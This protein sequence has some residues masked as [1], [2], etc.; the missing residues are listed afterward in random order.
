[1]PGENQHGDRIERDRH[2]PHRRPREREGIC[3]LRPE[4]RPHDVEP[5][6]CAGSRD[7]AI[8]QSTANGVEPVRDVHSSI[9]SDHVSWRYVES[10]TGHRRRRGGKMMTQRPRGGRGFRE[11]RYVSHAINRSR[12]EMMVVVVAM[13]TAGSQARRPCQL[14]CLCVEELTQRPLPLTRGAPA[15]GQSCAPSAE[16]SFR[17]R[18]QKTRNASPDPGVRPAADIVFAI[19]WTR[20]RAL[21]SSKGAPSCVT[22]VPPSRLAM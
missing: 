4:A 1:M 17:A 14:A 6:I 20:V 19:D 15:H 21:A 5:A 9:R 3:P 11:T 12:A 10:P 22:T 8:A 2:D 16:F 18:D 7:L 13:F